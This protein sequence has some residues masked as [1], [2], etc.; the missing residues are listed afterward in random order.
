MLFW[1]VAALIAL[2]VTGL[3]ALALLRGGTAEE[4]TAAYDLRVYRD[5]LKEIDRD[6]ARGIIPPEDADRM[7]TE[8]SR[9]V[10][11]ADRALAHATATG[12]E[13]PR[14]AQAVAIALALLA[15]GGALLLYQRIGAPGY[16]D[17]PLASRVAM[18]E[19]SLA[20]RPSQAE[21]EEAAREALGPPPELD[22]RFAELMERLRQVVSERPN[23]IQG[24][25]LLARNE[26]ATG[27]PAAGAAAQRRIVALKGPEAT[28]QD[29]AALADLM[30]LA[31]G[32]LVTA[33]AEAVL[34]EVLA[35]DG[36]N[37]TARYY[38]GLMLAQNG[39]PDQAF[40]VWKGLLDTS[41]PAAPWVPVILQQMPDLAFFAG[42]EWEAPARLTAPGPSEADIAA[43]A[44]MSAEDRGA[45]IRAMVDNLGARLAAEG[46]TAE[47]WARM[48][49]AL[50]VLGETDRAAA[51]WAEAQGVF[52][53]HPEM[54]ATVRAA[55]VQA[56]V[57]E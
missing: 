25:T 55:A 29:Y 36:Q 7:K 45:M 35:R 24:L 21:A 5:Q 42:E 28:A 30:V 37:G 41:D 17:L 39:R 15:A 4:P 44:E 43:A 47:E 50:G 13:E 22:P 56:G 27:N 51:I 48:I 33:E 16:P 32:G 6:L 9:R 10:L 11:E 18:A 3:V 54:L 40:R 53:E 19:E 26:A 52:A 57:A 14:A 31:A 46:G 20:S 2:A 12:R 8:V 23:D 34:N 1:I 49:G 38:V